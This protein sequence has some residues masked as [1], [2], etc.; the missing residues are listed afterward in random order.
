MPDLGIYSK[1]NRFLGGGY[2]QK[3]KVYNKKLESG[4]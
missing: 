4:R 2:W 1:E 3:E